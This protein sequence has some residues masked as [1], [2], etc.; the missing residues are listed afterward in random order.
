MNDQRK[1]VVSLQSA[2]PGPPEEPRNPYIAPGFNGP[3]IGAGDLGTPIG[4]PKYSGGTIFVT[5]RRR[6]NP[7]CVVCTA[8]V[9][10]MVEFLGWRF[11]RAGTVQYC[12]VA[13]LKRNRLWSGVWAHHG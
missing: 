6:A 8:P 12:T 11:V 3:P 10:S 9:A 13:V 5:A 1:T 2:L 7:C 4:I